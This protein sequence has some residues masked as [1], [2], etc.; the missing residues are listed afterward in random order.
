MLLK[1]QAALNTDTHQVQ[2]TG[3]SQT[4]QDLINLVAKQQLNPTATT[5]LTTNVLERIGRKVLKLWFQV[6]SFFSFV[7]EVFVLSCRSLLHPERIQWKLL[8]KVIES[9][10]YKAMPIIALLSF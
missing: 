5:T 7:G 1:L 9:G 8:L 2:F 6:L 4:Q 10:G 3:L